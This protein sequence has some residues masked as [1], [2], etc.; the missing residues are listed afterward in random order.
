M[1]QYLKHIWQEAKEHL[2]AKLN[3]P[4]EQ[5]QEIQELVNRY[6]S[7][8]KKMSKIDWNKIS[9]YTYEELINI[10]K[11][12]SKSQLKKRVRRGIA[13]I[14][15]NKEYIDI[16]FS[17]LES[18][19][20]YAPINYNG[21]VALGLKTNWCISA[22]E[23]PGHW[24]VY[25]KERRIV[26]I[27]LIDHDKKLKEEYQKICIAI[28]PD[29][30]IEIFD[31]HDASISIRTLENAMKKY[32]PKEFNVE[33]FI[34]QARNK[35][36]KIASKMDFPPTFEELKPGD[37]VKDHAEWY[38]VISAADDRHGT[39]TIRALSDNEEVEINYNDYERYMRDAERK[40]YIN[41]I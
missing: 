16:T 7:D 38:V 2:I 11:E 22:K 39:L 27:M 5:K 26:F 21:S 18:H 19:D 14:T 12:E 41:K 40:K 13:G 35:Y 3:L 32:N 30:R 34:T 20:A 28:S 37:G 10:L 15:R 9:K 8:K 1:K 24:N 36:K 25:T 33:S 23:N 4:D 17:N 6:A 29:K 31:L